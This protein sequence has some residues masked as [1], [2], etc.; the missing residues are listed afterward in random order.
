MDDAFELALVLSFV[1][2]AAAQCV[3]LQFTPELLRAAPRVLVALQRGAA[4]LAW[5]P[6]PT[7]R[8]F[9]LGDTA[10][11]PC[12]VDEV[13]AAHYGA[14]AVVH[15]GHTCLTPT[16]DLPALH[17]PGPWGADDAPIDVALCGAALAACVADAGDAHV[18]LV[19]DAALTA[20]LS[21]ILAAAAAAGGAGGVGSPVD[22]WSQVGEAEI[23]G[24]LTMRD[25]AD[26]E[27]GWDASD[28]THSWASPHPRLIVPTLTRALGP[29]PCVSRVQ[30]MPSSPRLR[31]CG[32]SVDAAALPP[33]L[34]HALLSTSSS[35]SDGDVAPL[36]L[37][38]VYIGS[39]E[40]RVRALLASFATCGGGVVT[41]SPSTGARMDATRSSARYMSSRYRLVG[42][43]KSAGAVGIVAGTLAV[44]RHTALVA[45]LRGALTRAGKC[46]YTLLVGKV[47]PSKLAN[48]VG[49]VDACILLACAETSLLSDTDIAAHALPVLTPFEALVALEEL[50]ADAEGGA[51]DGRGGDGDGDG[52]DASH[53]NPSSSSLALSWDGRLDLAFESLLLRF[54][55]S[56][57]GALAAAA[58]AAKVDVRGGSVGEGSDAPSAALGGGW[59][60]G[61]GSSSTLAVRNPH[62]MLLAQGGV[63]ST[64]GGRLQRR[65]WRGLAYETVEAGGEERAA[66]IE[67][68][69][70]GI[71]SVYVGGR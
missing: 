70:D 15:Y 47:T 25:A 2:R 61:G 53:A 52:G 50:A 3:A 13:A 22:A 24:T 40:S 35:G 57:C 12:C 10:Y 5:A 7:P 51:G 21:G 16:A 42:V 1:R 23:G 66:V 27:G 46:V 64:A 11:G 33:P 8:F 17:V 38:V 6:A 29:L 26:G 9:L 59:D 62:T 32:L 37:R 19:W 65:E 71:A 43:L 41:L 31:V 54:E 18:L 67:E 28:Y 69:R 30:S 60:A 49:S 4:A 14:D 56:A 58:A 39:R 55:R 20:T 44:A 48:F 68:G 34:Q 36:P 63:S 45:A